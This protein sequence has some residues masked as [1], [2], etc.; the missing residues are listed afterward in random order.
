MKSPIPFAFPIPFSLAA[1]V[2]LLAGCA[3]SP[4]SSLPVETVRSKTGSISSV[5]TTEQQGH[6][7][8]TGKARTTPSIRPGHVDVQLLAADHRVI[9]G[10]SDPISRSHPRGSQARHGTA[11]FHACFPAD[12]VRTAHR[13]RVTY[14]AGG[15]HGCPVPPSQS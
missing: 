12:E 4:H 10:Q 2:L 6:L 11:S 1:F 14:H 8:V 9:A 7:I 5:H 15:H 3:T 13:L